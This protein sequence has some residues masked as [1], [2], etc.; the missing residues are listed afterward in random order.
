MKQF[1]WE[2]KK[3]LSEDF[4]KHCIEKFE[5]DE[6]KIVGM[7]G[8][9]SIVDLSMKRSLDLLM[10]VF[11]QWNEEDRVF[12]NSIHNCL[13]EYT[14]Y[15]EKEFNKNDLFNPFVYSEKYNSNFVDSGYQI[16]R[17]K[18]GEF[19]DWHSDTNIM[20][21]PPKVRFRAITYIWYLNDV[22]DEGYTEFIDGTKIIPEAG[23]L[24]LFP[25][26]WEYV[27]RGVSPKKDTKYIATGWFS[28]E[29][30]IT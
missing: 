18:P 17:T 19:Y 29:F 25:A 27:H 28:S 21:V 30:T 16:Q 13:Y 15:L 11:P 14:N 26:T 24:L 3:E 6:N 5:S 12:F 23:K 10:S 1:I 20:V 22:L 4:C 7:L 8:T 9:D 2:K